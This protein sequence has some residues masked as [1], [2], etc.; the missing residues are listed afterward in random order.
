MNMDVPPTHQKEGF[1]PGLANDPVAH[2]CGDPAELFERLRSELSRETVCRRNEP[3]ARR[4]TL[5]VGGS[6]DVYVEPSGEPE[7]AA[8]MSIV[9]ALN[10]PWI[11]LGRGSNLLVLDGG[12]RGVVISLVNPGFASI[13]SR[14]RSLICGAGARLKLVAMEAKRREIG[15]LEFIE[16]IPGS[17][18]GA[19]RM[20]AGA[21]G[22]SIFER[23]DRIRFMTSEGTIRERR[24]SDVDVT[25]R[26]CAFLERNIAIQA[27]LT[28]GFVP[29]AEIERR[30]KESNRKRWESQPAASSAGCIFKN[31]ES[32]PAGKLVDELG[33]KGARVGAASVSEVHGNFIVNEGGAKARDVLGLIELIRERARRERGIELETEVRIIGSAQ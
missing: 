5:R 26:H 29:R 25:Y 23:I 19:L 10:A 30:L 17:V 15:G 11:I 14:D 4:T 13:E 24:G 18:G 8:V 16:G 32:I 27:V 21:M 12:V 9:R 1:Q 28:G 2:A 22:H 20:N 7:L 33:L 31:P 3:L 6:A